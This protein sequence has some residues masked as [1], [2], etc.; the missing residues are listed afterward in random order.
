MCDDHLATRLCGATSMVRAGSCEL[1]L[2]R[3]QAQTCDAYTTP[4]E[5][6]SLVAS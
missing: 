6:T 2:S 3:F 1:P 5:L 4:A